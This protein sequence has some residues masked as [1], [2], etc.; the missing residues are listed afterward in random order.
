MNEA[1]VAAT[2]AQVLWAV[3]LLACAFGA[4]VQRSHFCTMGAV[5]D[6]VHMGDWARMRNWVFAMGVAIT[7]F[8][9]MAAAGWVQPRHSIY[10]GPTLTWLSHLAGGAIF[11]FGMVLA[12]GCGSKN[13]ARAGS[14]SLKAVV[15]LMA[16]AISA[17]ATMRGLFA[18]W[19][20]SVLERVAVDLP[21]GQDLPTLIGAATDLPAAQLAAWF[22]VPVGLAVM[23][24]AAWPRRGGNRTP[25]WAGLGLG[26]IVVAV[27]W[28][29]G[30]LGF[31]AEHPQTLEEAFVA[32]HSRRMESLTFV[33]PVAYSMDW[34]I[35]Y[36]DSSRRLTLGIVGTLGV[37]A[38]SAAAAL[39]TRTFRWEAF[40]GIEDTANHLVGGVLM[41]IGGVAALGC[42]IGQGLSGVSTL[43]LGSL[44][45][46][47]SLMA[48]AV[49]GLRY[50]A[51]RV[52]AA[53]G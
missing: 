35:L 16:L 5:A 43:A 29:S 17:Y 25:L 34:L 31:L 11:G 12:S 20:V 46:V 7:G 6:I 30:S 45:T 37:L 13:L 24:W 23:A 4:I 26:T 18:V 8:Q 19:R 3:F 1:D 36:S 41:G 47:A 2:T 44:I 42:T 28:V 49:A 9:A 14:G 51:W 39:A 38:G 27:W 32:T 50:Q 10:T 52:D 15:V 21:A 40:R 33:A 22:G 48:G 53:E